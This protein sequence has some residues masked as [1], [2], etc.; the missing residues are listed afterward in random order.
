MWSAGID[1]YG[2]S[3]IAESFRHGDRPGRLDL[4]QDDGHARRPGPGRARSGAA[5]RSTAPSG[6]RRRCSSSTGART[7][8]SCRS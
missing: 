2:D 5:R 6:S 1:L 4:Q 8:A 7:S 3:E